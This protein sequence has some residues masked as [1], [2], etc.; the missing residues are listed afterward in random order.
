MSCHPP[1]SCIKLT[2]DTPTTRTYFQIIYKNNNL[3]IQKDESEFVEY[4][5]FTEYLNNY[6]LRITPERYYTLNNVQ[7]PEE[8]SL[9][10]I[11]DPNSF[12]L[13]GE[14]M[15]EVL[16]EKSIDLKNWEV[17]MLAKIPDWYQMEIGD[18]SEEGEVF[19][20]AHTKPLDFDP[21]IR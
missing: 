2:D 21:A 14:N 15:K 19:Y 18:S 20:R 17:Y 10:R 1:Y 6:G 13:Q 12:Y 3:V 11:E 5:K 9:L 16:I 4:N 8:D 7:I